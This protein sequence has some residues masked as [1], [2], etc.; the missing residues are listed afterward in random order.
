M[1]RFSLTVLRNSIFGMGAQ[2]IIK[3]LSFA[4]TVL[5]VRKL[6]TEAF[7]QYSAV[8]AFGA[9][10]VF[11]ADLGL[12]PYTVRQIARWRDAIDAHEKINTFF[13]NILLL[14]F[15]LSLLAATLLIATAWL[16]GRPPIMVFAIALGTIGLIMYS[17]Q[18]TADAVLAGFERLD[19]SA[20]SK[21]SYQIIFVAV[22]GIALWFG[23]G[24]FGLIA[25]NLMGIA[26]MTA[27]CWRGTQL[28]GTKPTAPTPQIWKKLLR[29][30]IPFGIIGFTLGLS[31]KFD[32]VLLNIYRGDTETGYYNAAYSL[33]FSTVILSNIVNTALYPSMT[34]QAASEPHTLSKIYERA[35]R[36]LLILSLPIAIGG[37]TLADQIVP[38]LFGIEYAAAIS[39]LQIVIW[40][41]PLMFA[42]EFLGYIVVISG[43]ES[44]IA[45]AIMIS[46]GFNVLLNFLLIPR[47]GVW[48]AAIMTL[49]TEIVLVSQYL[50]MLRDTLRYFNGYHVL[51]RPLVA[52]LLMGG[53]AFL[54]HGVL[55]LLLNVAIGVVVYAILLFVLKVLSIEEVKFFRSLGQRKEVEAS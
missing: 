25:A 18:G 37:A 45:R 51:L 1:R 6:G 47:F 11:I 50:W 5:I 20:G 16:T 44:Q 3:V 21:I 13:G 12:S 24:Y 4:F 46:T 40:V 38:F 19:L 35:L 32:S 42:S 15:F 53:I 28:V 17:V 27:I 52:A 39:I 22:G 43:K 30:S 2:L 33:V 9:M 29:Q 8:L 48:S 49:L 55:P 14:R 31:Y 7:G 34:R 54:L 10:F 23:A 36:Y 26:A 41:V